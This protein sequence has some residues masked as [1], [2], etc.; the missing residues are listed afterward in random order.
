[1]EAL[2][3]ESRSC[4]CSTEQE[5]RERIEKELADATQQHYEQWPDYKRVELILRIGTICYANVKHLRREIWNPFLL[6]IYER[7]KL[8][9]PMITYYAPASMVYD[10]LYSTFCQAFK[11][12]MKKYFDR[13]DCLFLYDLPIDNQLLELIH[14]IHKKRATISSNDSE[15]PIYPSIV[16]LYHGVEL[17]S[18]KQEE[19]A[20][21]I[22]KKG[23]ER[24]DDPDHVYCKYLYGK[25]AHDFKILKECSDQGCVYSTIYC[26][27]QLR[28]PIYMV[29]VLELKLLPIPNTMV[30]DAIKQLPNKPKKIPT[31][32]LQTYE[33]L[34]SDCKTLLEKFPSD[35]NIHD[36][37]VLD[38]A[39]KPNK[40]LEMI[41]KKQGAFDTYVR[42]VI[43]LLYQHA[44]EDTYD[45]DK[46][47][48]LSETLYEANLLCPKELVLNKSDPDYI[49]ILRD[50]YLLQLWIQQ[51]EQMC[52][53]LLEEIEYLPETGAVYKE[54]QNFVSTE[55]N[56]QEQDHEQ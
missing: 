22:L 39:Q 36:R 19:T 7:F 44:Q 16:Y 17:L 46:I 11:K 23:A 45:R 37:Y 42:E 41:M 26:M 3:Q 50:Y 29:R 32:L 18:K 52:K 30:D 13:C 51:L 24:L 12:N 8:S 21:L 31:N 9:E 14:L 35:S 25:H 5:F 55:L 49:L 20:L 56:G 4:I 6:S 15:G 47:R 38:I 28:D 40:V 10:A 27:Q 43:P 53:D 34:M 1:M 54:I 48:K 33:T 2:V